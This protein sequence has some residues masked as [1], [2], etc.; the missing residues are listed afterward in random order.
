MTEKSQAQIVR[1]LSV[2]ALAEHFSPF[3]CYPWALPTPG[4]LTVAMVETALKAN[5]GEGECW[6]SPLVEDE[7]QLWPLERHAQRVAWL[8]MHGW[9]E[10]VEF[11]CY[12][13][14]GH[15]LLDGYHRLGAAIILRSETI[16]AYVSGLLAMAKRFY[17]PAVQ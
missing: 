3:I 4:L 10:P 13:R 7:R 9:T 6:S 5:K 11:E 1:Q 16:P 15:R 12:P 17:A 8:V 14:T 2:P